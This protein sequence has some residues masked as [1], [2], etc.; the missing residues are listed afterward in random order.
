MF[1]LFFVLKIFVV[2]FNVLK[3]RFTFHEA[4]SIVDN[5]MCKSWLHACRMTMAPEIRTIFDTTGCPATTL[6][7]RFHSTLVLAATSGACSAWL[8]P[9]YVAI[10]LKRKAKPPDENDMHD[11]PENAGHGGFE[12]G[13]LLAKNTDRQNGKCVGKQFKQYAFTFDA[14]LNGLRLRWFLRSTDVDFMQLS[15]IV[16]RLTLSPALVAAL[17]A[18][19]AR[20]L[21]LPSRRVLDRGQLKLDILSVGWYRHELAST[22]MHI[23]LHADASRQRSINFY[24]LIQD[25]LAWPKTLS[26]R[27]QVQL[28]VQQHYSRRICPLSVLAKTGASTNI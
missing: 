18:Q 14:I 1:Y 20:N 21:D 23:C 16:W 25:V 26:L 24:C 17:Q 5:S 13:D 22:S 8:S 7:I 2:I 11:E 28:D 6:T 27:E 15:Q 12:H 4:E 9:T 10:H 19:A 3:I